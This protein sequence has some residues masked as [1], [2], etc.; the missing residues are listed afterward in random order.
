MLKSPYVYSDKLFNK[1]IYI[2]KLIITFHVSKFVIS[3]SAIVHIDSTVS[4]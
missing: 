2:V 4:L 1:Y 3:V